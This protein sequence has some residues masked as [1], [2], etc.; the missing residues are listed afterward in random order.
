MTKKLK[1][2]IRYKGY[3]KYKLDSKGRIDDYEIVEDEDYDDTTYKYIPGTEGLEFFLSKF[4]VEEELRK[5][6]SAKKPNNRRLEILIEL[7]KH[8]PDFSAGVS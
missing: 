3:L 5:E 2:L 1:A 4:D 6:K 8:N 7:K